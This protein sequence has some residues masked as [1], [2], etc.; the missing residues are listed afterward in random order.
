MNNFPFNAIVKVITFIMRSLEITTSESEV[1][2][3][4]KV[5][6]SNLYAK[7]KLTFSRL[8]KVQKESIPSPRL[9]SALQYL[10]SFS[11]FSEAKACLKVYY[12]ESKCA[13]S[14]FTLCRKKMRNKSSRTYYCY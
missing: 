13:L 8:I 4:K 2:P 6:I 3:I 12:N 1:T 5:A 7:H 9:G 14:A 10:L 11:G